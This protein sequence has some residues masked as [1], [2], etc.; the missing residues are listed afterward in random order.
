MPQSSSPPAAVDEAFAS[1]FAVDF[2][3]P[4]NNPEILGRLGEYEI[5]DV[6]GRGGM[7]IVLKGHQRELNRYVAVIRPLLATVVTITRIDRK[8]GSPKPPGNSQAGVVID[9]RGYILTL[10]F[11]HNDGDDSDDPENQQIK[12]GF[13]YGTEHIAE[14][15]DNDR[16]LGMTILKVGLSRPCPAIALEQI[17]EV[18]DR[19]R[20]YL[21]P[22]Q[23]TKRVLKGRITSTSAN[24]GNGIPILVESDIRLPA[25]EVGSLLVTGQGHPVGILTSMAIGKKVS[26]ALPLT[27]AISFINEA[28]APESSDEPRQP[29][30]MQ[31]AMPTPM[32]PPQRRRPAAVPRSPEA[33]RLLEQ[34]HARESA[35]F[36]EAETIRRLQ[37][38]GNAEKNKAAIA[39]HQRKL[40][41]LLGAAF[42]LKLNLEALQVKELRSRLSRLEQQIGQRQAVRQNWLRTRACNGTRRVTAPPIPARDRNERQ[43]PESQ[44]MP[45]ICP[46]HH[47]ATCCSRHFG[48]VVQTAPC[49]RSKTPRSS[50]EG[51]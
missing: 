24:F 41:G 47:L 25:G 13:S 48:L 12:V 44:L 45:P 9:S 30:R 39:E 43:L 17:R 16:S 4:D 11:D 35:A 31:P 18:V 42:D 26:Y 29:H 8:T 49:N 19:R 51:A 36:A 14:I 46:T 3:E 40:N 1:D 15:A 32:P 5:L 20:V 10:S 7:G 23:V 27:A 37:A 33:V 2:L 6:I 21:V 34:L 38:D 50:G 22:Q 28:T